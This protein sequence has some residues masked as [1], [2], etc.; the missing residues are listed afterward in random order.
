MFAFQPLPLHALR[1]RKS[2][3]FQPRLHCAATAFAP[4]PTPRSRLRVRFQSG[5]QVVQAVGAGGA[6]VALPCQG[7]D[8]LPGLRDGC[9]L[10]TPSCFICFCSAAV[11]SSLLLP[12]HDAV[13]LSAAQVAFANG[14]GGVRTGQQFDHFF[15]FGQAR[16]SNSLFRAPRSANSCC[17]ICCA[18]RAC[19]SSAS[20]SACRPVPPRSVAI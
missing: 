14:A 18:S 4:R 13:A 20:T 15:Q 9:F 10:A 7:R 16:R 6:V 5:G 2:S 19:A 12:R 8:A 3:F 11:G 1:S 17:A